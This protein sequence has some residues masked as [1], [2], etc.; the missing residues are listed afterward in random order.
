MRIPAIIFPS[1]LCGSVLR[2][3]LLCGSLFRGSLLRGSLLCGFMLFGSLLCGLSLRAQ[4]QGQA[5]ADSLEHALSGQTG[6]TN[7]VRT[8][9]QLTRVWDGI[10]PRK[11]FSFADRGM[12]LA[13]KLSYRQGIA[14]LNNSLGLLT[15]DTGNNTQAR[16][17]FEKSLAINM[18]L[19][20]K[21]NMIANL[22]N[23]G[24]SYEREADFPKASANYFKAL[25]LAQETGNDAQAA[26]VGTNILSMY[27]EEQDYQK[28][29]AYG[30]STIKWGRAAN[31]LIHVAKAYEMIGVIYLQNNDTPRSRKN[32]ETALA[33]YKQLGNQIAAVGALSNL[34]TLESDPQKNVDIALEAQAILDSA[35]PRSQN[36]IMNQT[37]IGGDYM[38]LGEAHHAAQQR[39][40]YTLAAKY[41]GR[42][43][44]L[45]KVTGILTFEPDIQVMLSNLAED[46]GDYKA[47][48]ASYKRFK[49]LNDS[50]FSQ[51]SKNK[52]AKLESQRAIDLKN[53]EIENK[54]LQ[55]SNQ[56]KTMWMLVIGVALLGSIGIILWRQTALRK[57]TNNQ[58]VR[59]NTELNEANKVKAKFLGILS[60]DLRSPIARLLNFLQLQ[61][62]KPDSLNPAEKVEYWERLS[63]SATTLLDTMEAMLLWSKGQM[64]VFKPTLAPVAVA[65]LFERLRRFFADVPGADFEFTVSAGLAV[66]TDE[67]YLWT[68]MQNLTANA[69]THSTQPQSS[70]PQSSSPQS[71]S[72]H[73]GAKVIWRAWQESATVYCSILDNG[74]GVTEEQLRALFDETVG[75]GAR[76]GLGLHIIRDLAKAIDCRITMR[77]GPGQGTE[78]VLQL[79]PPIL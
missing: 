67:D 73:S 4:K 35:A 20:S 57:R 56:R 69:V 13:Q 38:T 71:S 33:L 7:T 28:A 44:S 1:L 5:L 41:I 42:A 10:D 58:L 31:A 3:S 70:P 68:I 22:S 34:A 77:P 16:V 37:N 17:Y 53:K 72:P 45:S 63:A 9:V 78:F 75:A 26:L 76:Q 66:N 64:E 11:G 12:H 27:I 29:I 79:Q 47:A 18:A 15:G 32:Y 51:D 46:R 74:P 19:D 6:D 62:K 30:D 54:G 39:T 48:L 65:A 40:Y 2:G 21:N 24:R 43:D 52:I 55:I 59:L 49:Y 8:Y 61:K 36:S 23:I 50:I 14:N 25:A 60:H